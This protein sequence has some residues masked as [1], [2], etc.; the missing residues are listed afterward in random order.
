MLDIKDIRISWCFHL[1]WAKKR[2]LDLSKLV[3]VGKKRVRSKCGKKMN[4]ED[5]YVYYYPESIYGTSLKP[6]GSGEYYRS[7]V[8][9]GEING[10]DK[11]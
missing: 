3:Y 11:A 7:S 1:A 6:I 8:L 10:T 5:E 9:L 2:N 4:Y